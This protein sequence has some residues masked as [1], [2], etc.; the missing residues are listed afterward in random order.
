MAKLQ[1]LGADGDP[2]EVPCDEQL[3]CPRR[4]NGVIA[5]PITALD[6]LNYR[7]PDPDWEI[8]GLLKGAKLNGK[9]VYARILIRRTY[10]SWKKRGKNITLFKPMEGE[11]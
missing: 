9:E 7:G 10:E 4:C 8:L 5:V 1:V 11:E 6:K 3:T 2:Q